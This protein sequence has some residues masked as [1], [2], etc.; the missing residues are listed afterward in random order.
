MS[1]AGHKVWGLG[2]CDLLLRKDHQPFSQAQALD[3]FFFFFLMAAIEAYGSSWA[4]GQL[5]PSAAVLSHS[6]SNTGLQR[7]L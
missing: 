2:V 7:P 1:I 3:L 6:H 5:G 4:H